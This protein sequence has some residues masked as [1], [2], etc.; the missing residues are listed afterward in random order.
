M[1]DELN[2]ANFVRSGFNFFKKSSS[3]VTE[4]SVEI[5]SES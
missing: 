2:I 3:S 5:V 4:V 1:A